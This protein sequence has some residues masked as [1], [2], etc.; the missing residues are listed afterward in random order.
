MA[1]SFL[2]TMLADA[3]TDVSPSL[4][5]QRETL[6]VYFPEIYGADACIF[7][8]GE[9]TMLVDAAT[10]GQAPVVMET[11]EKLGLTIPPERLRPRKCTRRDTIVMNY[12][13]EKFL[14]A[15]RYLNELLDE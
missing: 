11:L 2:P 5:Q 14:A 15:H 10:V 3:V 13:L 7:R 8:F 1:F 9:E 12:H 4:L 6:E